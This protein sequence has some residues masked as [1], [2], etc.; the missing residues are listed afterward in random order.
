MAKD[1]DILVR[2]YEIVLQRRKADPDESYVAKRFKQGTP[3]IA[4]KFGEEAV[5]TVVAAMREDKDEVIGESADMIFHWLLLL[6][7]A[8]V[9][10][11]EVM[12][13][14]DR[15]TGLSGLDEKALRQM[16]EKEKEKAK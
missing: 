4:Q 12:K 14:L 10:P 15:R 1:M 6:A 5:E 13:E 16:K 2:L 11:E 9:R 8:G 7:D 3:K